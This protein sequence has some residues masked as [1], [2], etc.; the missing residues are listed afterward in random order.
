MNEVFL[1]SNHRHVSPTHVT[2]FRV[3]RT[4][5]RTRLQ[6]VEINPHIENSYNLC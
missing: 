4:K 6:R 1:H 3:E 2:I 5:T